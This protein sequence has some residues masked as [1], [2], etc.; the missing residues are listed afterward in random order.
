MKYLHI[1]SII[2]LLSSCA[3]EDVSIPTR[4]QY[5]PKG[6][7][8]KGMVKYLNQ[9]ADSIIAERKE[10]AFKKMSTNCN[11]NYRIINEGPNEEGGVI[12]KIS[13]SSSML[14]SSQYWYISYECLN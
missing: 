5:A 6:Y 8:P 1:L 13:A 11:G 14:S 2:F 12:T 7:V 4:S 9:G 10:D 3:S